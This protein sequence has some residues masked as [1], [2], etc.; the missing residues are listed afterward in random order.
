[1]E[2]HSLPAKITC[3]NSLGSRIPTEHSAEVSQL[4][5]EG[6]RGHFSAAQVL[7]FLQVFTVCKT[8]PRD[9]CKALSWEVFIKLLI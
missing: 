9:I 8:V 7:T 3:S 4:H 2:L 6:L 1:M 5:K